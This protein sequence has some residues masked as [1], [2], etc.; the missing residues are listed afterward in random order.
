MTTATDPD[1]AYEW[2]PNGTLDMY[3]PTGTVQGILWDA[4]RGKGNFG[5]G[6]VTVAQVD[7]L[8]M[9]CGVPSLV[10]AP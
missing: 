4:E 8:G 6:V 9:G 1:G 3:T 10:V 7:E 5:I 2:H